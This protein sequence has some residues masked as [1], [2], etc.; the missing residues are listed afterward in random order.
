MTTQSSTA[1]TAPDSLTGI[2]LALEGVE[3]SQVLLNGPTGCK[4]YHAST[5]DTMFPRG[6]EF[7]VLDYP[8]RWYFR[9]PRVPCTYLDNTDYVYGSAEKLRDALGFF[10]ERD[11]DVLAIVN[12]PG[13]SL[14]GDD[15]QGLVEECIPG[16]PVLVFETPGFSSDVC[17]GHETAT[18]R[19]LEELADGEAP[20]FDEPTVNLLGINMFQRNHEGDAAEL[21]R[22]LGLC[23]VR[24]NA[25]LTCGC[26]TEE[27]ARVPA[28]DL[29]VV[30]HPEFGT[31]TAAWL[32]ERFGMQT[33]ALPGAPVGF[34]A[35]ERFVSE[36][37]ERVGADAASA[38]EDCARARARAYGYVAR[39]NVT[40][41]LPK[42][43]PF[44]VEA[45]CSLAR[46]YVEFLVDYLAMVPAS[47]ENAFPRSEESLPALEALLAE[48]GLSDC[49][50][51]DI[52]ET[53]AE[54]VFA[55]GETIARKQL[56]DTR[57]SGVEIALP[58]LGYRDVV[59]KTHLGSQGA[60]QLIE[61]V[62]NGVML[63]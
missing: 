35:T 12:N 56:A 49:L 29:N 37:C 5:S 36:V 59:P 2:I 16:R 60:L 45:S 6:L 50:Q 3:H 55:S 25:V 10:A 61:A 13:A 58:S 48:Y 7:D 53:H 63:D 20:A 43:V 30:V 19:L 62:L 9:Q 1:V 47:V 44:S 22:L 31:Q 24:V 18:I 15:L 26:T 54:L 11:F 40:T 41:G 33:L 17:H 52:V 32:E 4:Y 42:A 23:G 39:L 38:L 27:L 51:R 14:I 57:F 46:S 8:D 34:A 21:G 28:A